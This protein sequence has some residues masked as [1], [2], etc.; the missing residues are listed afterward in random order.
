MTCETLFVGI[1]VSK[2]KHDIVIMNDNKKPLLKPFAIQEN[3]AGYLYLIDK[4]HQLK[5]SL[6]KLND[7]SATFGASKSWRC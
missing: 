6:L 2:L 4:L 3:H 1:D 7:S 5:R